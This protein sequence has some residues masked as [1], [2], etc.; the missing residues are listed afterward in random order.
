MASVPSDIR[1]HSHHLQTPEP[2]HAHVLDDRHGRLRQAAPYDQAVAHAR[3]SAMAAASRGPLSPRDLDIRSIALPTHQKPKTSASRRPPTP[4]GQAIQLDEAILNQPDVA[5]PIFPPTLMQ[6]K[7]IPRW[8]SPC[9]SM[10]PFAH[11]VIASSVIILTAGPKVESDFYSSLSKKPFETLGGLIL[12]AASLAVDVLISP[13]LEVCEKTTLIQKINMTTGA[14]FSIFGAYGAFKYCSE[15]N[16]REVAVA[17]V[18][19]TIR[20]ISSFLE[21]LWSRNNRTA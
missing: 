9:G 7:A 5:I 17:S 18:F 21:V 6:I 16:V 19:L 2:Q 3:Q 12:P 10:A 4:L 15:D 20:G 13:I 11:K 8:K 1:S 14:L